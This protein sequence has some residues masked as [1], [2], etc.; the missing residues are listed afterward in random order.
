MSAVKENENLPQ[1]PNNVQKTMYELTISHAEERIKRI[2]DRNNELEE[3]LEQTKRDITST[4]IKTADEI[5]H[6]NRLLSV[7]STKID[8]CQNGMSVINQNQL[9]EKK[10]ND[11]IIDTSKELYKNTQLKLLSKMKILNAKI[12]VLEDFKNKKPALENKIKNIDE[13][14]M[15]REEEMQK[16]LKQIDIKFKLDREKLIK[17][18]HMKLFELNKSWTSN[19]D[20]EESVTVRRLIQENIAIGYELNQNITEMDNKKHYYLQSKS[21]MEL[22]RNSGKHRQIDTM[23]SLVIMKTQNAL[24]KQLRKNCQQQK[25]HPNILPLTKNVFTD[26]N[27]L[28]DKLQ[29]DILRC[30]VEI[31]NLKNNLYNENIKVENA[32]NLK[33]RTEKKIKESINILYDVKYVIACALQISH[34]GPSIASMTEFELITHLKNLVKNKYTRKNMYKHFI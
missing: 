25:N 20:N 21:L 11:N 12:N 24:I 15:Q 18:L 7:E 28:I 14:M 16:R 2:Q 26:Y 3:L 1:Y 10:E 9:E 33:K 30:E 31:A 4:D 29:F 6:L 32:R 17:N 27:S 34:C 5:V 19:K 22:S 23:K 8:D 13:L